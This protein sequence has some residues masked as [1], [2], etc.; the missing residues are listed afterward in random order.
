[1]QA[2]VGEKEEIPALQLCLDSRRDF[3]PYVWSVDGRMLAT[4][5][6]ELNKWLAGKIANH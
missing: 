4:E 6:K 3:T 5:S 2:R 1:V